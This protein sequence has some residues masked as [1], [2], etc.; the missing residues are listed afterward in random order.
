MA[1]T[2]AFLNLDEVRSA[3]IRLRAERDHV[4]EGL[5]ARLQLVREPE[6]RKAVVGDAMGDL[7]RSWK[8]FRTVK[9]MFG[10]TA[11]LTSKA[12]GLVVGAKAKTPAGRV[13][14][15]LASFIL[16][17][18]MEKFGK[19]CGIDPDKL[20]HEFGVSWERVKDYVDQRRAAREEANTE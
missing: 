5:S 7:L 4:Q 12:I 10:G 17:A 2:E 8:P 14:V 13:M 19:R 11:G 3:K 18:L 15:A 1:K 16:P 6:F 9:A 20:Q